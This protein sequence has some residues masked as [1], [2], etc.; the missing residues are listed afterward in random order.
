VQEHLHDQESCPEDDQVDEHSDEEDQ[1][2]PHGFKDSHE[3]LHQKRDQ[4]RSKDR[5]EIGLE[6]TYGQEGEEPHSD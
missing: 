4:D 6:A 3:R 5:P 2:N 1:E